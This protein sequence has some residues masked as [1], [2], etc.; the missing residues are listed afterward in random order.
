MQQK[1]KGMKK[2]YSKELES[3]KPDPQSRKYSGHITGILGK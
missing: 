1:E 2:F 3:E